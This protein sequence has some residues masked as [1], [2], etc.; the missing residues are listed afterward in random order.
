[1]NDQVKSDDFVS[2]IDEGLLTASHNI[3]ADNS[4]LAGYKKTE[5]GLIPKD[6]IVDKIGSL[7]SYQNG[8]AQ[9]K[10][11]NGSHGYKVISIGNYSEEGRY[12]PTE[13]Y[14]H[15]AH[16][17]SVE[18]FIMD[19][20]DL[21]MI[22][23]DKTSIGTI[24]GRVLLIEED[25][26][27][28]MN[29]RTMRLKC[30]GSVSPAYM[31]K[32]INS[33]FI[34]KKIVGLAKPGTQIYI[35]TNDVLSIPLPYPKSKDE[36][37]AITKAL[38]DVD[39]LIDSLEALIAKKQAIKTATMQ[40]LLTGRNRLPQFARRTDD[41]LKGTK[42]SELGEIPE[43]WEISV[44]GDICNF[45]KGAGL[46]KSDMDD[47][48]KHPCI[49]YGQ[50]FTDYGP[51]IGTIKSA[52]E[53]YRPNSVLSESNDILMPTSDVTPNGLAKASCIKQDGVILG[54][55]I[56]VIRSKPRML[57]GVFFSYLVGIIR[58]RVMQLVT[59]STVYHLYGSEMAKLSIPKPPFQ[60]QEA[61]ANVL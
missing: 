21:A 20:G 14:I 33:S 1:M 60:E 9:E 48:A 50:L 57:D 22:L 58:D 12:V 2:P 30:K 10:L 25:D 11:F 49:H 61:I 32:L 52:T 15:T 29:Q 31:H 18:K 24:I 55:D 23:N 43:D 41:T 7:C 4:A 39:A 40:Q 51:L 19:A 36:Q 6:W 37:N 38:S 17:S 28:V 54:G 16:R 27:Y 53:T 46:P 44:L 35:N 42:N 8:T 47:H 26:S 3:E 45:A 5:V 13:T 59:G 56:L 34:H